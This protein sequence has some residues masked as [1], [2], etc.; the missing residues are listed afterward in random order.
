MFLLELLAA[1]SIVLLAVGTGTVVHELLHAALLRLAGVDCEVR[2]LHGGRTGRLGAGLFGTWASVR[3]TAIP[4]TLDPW[5]LRL[6][7][8]SPLFLAAPLVAIASGVLPDPFATGNLYVQ[9]A[10]V[11]WLACALPSPADF[12]LVWNA[13][14]VIAGDT[15]PV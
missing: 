1:V 13:P 3:M 12:S 2:W 15:A 6:A 8:L 10:L 4:G 14:S 7:A 11:G 9:F 5:Q